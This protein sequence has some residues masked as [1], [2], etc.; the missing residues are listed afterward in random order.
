MGNVNNVMSN[1]QNAFCDD[2]GFNCDKRA[3]V[4][5]K[6]R[7]VRF[8]VADPTM[9]NHKNQDG[10][11]QVEK[12]QNDNPKVLKVDCVRTCDSLLDMNNT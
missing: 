9:P 11:I 3:D 12:G 6:R 8:N 10:L 4:G 2:C 1:A 7:W 5:S